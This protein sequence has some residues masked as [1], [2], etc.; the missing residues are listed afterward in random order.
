MKIPIIRAQTRVRGEFYSEG[1]IIR[2]TRKS[3]CTKISLEL[4]IE[5]PGVPDRIAQLV[6]TAETMCLVSQSMANPVPVQLS[7]MHNGQGISLSTP[8]ETGSGDVVS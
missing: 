2:G 6:R 8:T 5:S 3:G 4:Q 7:V 1:S